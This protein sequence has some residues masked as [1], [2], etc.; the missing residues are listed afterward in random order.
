M[1]VLIGNRK[2]LPTTVAKYMDLRMKY[3]VIAFF[4]NN[5]SCV[6]TLT[7]WNSR[8]WYMDWNCIYILRTS[9]FCLKR[10]VRGISDLATMH[11]DRHWMLE[12]ESLSLA[13]PV[14]WLMYMAITL[15]SY[16]NSF[17]LNKKA[18]GFGW[19]R[20]TNQQLNAIRNLHF[21][22]NL[23]FLYPWVHCITHKSFAFY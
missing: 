2:I 4:L 12:P 17:D 10:Q 7:L 22:I 20:C 5:R 18:F 9:P 8:K 16:S 15:H 14:D 21:D 11:G 13:I 1:G 3:K 6:S 19:W 23:Y